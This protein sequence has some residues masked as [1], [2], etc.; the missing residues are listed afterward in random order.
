MLGVAGVLSS[1]AGALG[2]GVSVGGCCFALYTDRTTETRRSRLSPVVT[3]PRVTFPRATRPTPRMVLTSL[4]A[5]PAGAAHW[6][7][8]GWHAASV[9]PG[10]TIVTATG[11]TGPYG[12]AWPSIQSPSRALAAVRLGRPEEALTCF[13]D[14]LS[15]TK[16]APKQRAIVMLEVATAARRRRSA[17]H[18]RLLLIRARGGE[19]PAFSPLLRRPGYS[20]RPEL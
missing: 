2:C 8:L 17:E 19:S 16:P 14:S 20:L 12:C 9:P 13:A 7:G 5:V 10:R 1:G 11:T 6:P 18:R 15:A 3:R 4:S